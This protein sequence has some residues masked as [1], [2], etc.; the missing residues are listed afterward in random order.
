MDSWRELV[1]SRP[2]YGSGQVI[3]VPKFAE[4]FFFS[5]SEKGT[6]SIHR[7]FGPESRG[8]SERWDGLRE[9]ARPQRCSHPERERKRVTQWRTI[10]PVI[11]RG[12]HTDTT[13][14]SLTLAEYSQESEAERILKK[15]AHTKWRNVRSCGQ[16]F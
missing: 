10:E 7:E 3:K 5:F 6:I 15:H 4:T 16:Q 9:S 1:I 8:V 13:F 11:S 12:I 2:A 14:S